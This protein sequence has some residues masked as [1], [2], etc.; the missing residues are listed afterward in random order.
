MSQAMANCRIACKSIILSRVTLE[1][2]SCNLDL[3]GN[4]L[5]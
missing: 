2:N 4:V 5:Y 1:F 3:I